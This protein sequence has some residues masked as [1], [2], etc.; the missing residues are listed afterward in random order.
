MMEEYMCEKKDCGRKE[1]KRCCIDLII[2]I[3]SIA[4][5]FTV[6]LIVGALVSSTIII[7][8]FPQKKPIFHDCFLSLLLDLPD[9][10]TFLFSSLLY[11]IVYIL[12]VP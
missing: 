6:G 11:N 10:N 4:L 5:I 3:I 1:K 8:Y 12:V 7:K 2:V 9:L